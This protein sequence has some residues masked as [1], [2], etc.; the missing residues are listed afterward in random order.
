MNKLVVDEPFRSK[1]QCVESRLELCDDAG[2]TLGFFVPV[3]EREGMLY[4]WAR[5]EFSDEEIDR[6]RAE[7]G[8][9][10]L[11]QILADLPS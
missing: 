2:N 9:F 5:G 7:P 10:S 6:A 11:A 3:S 4:A 1:L 8:G